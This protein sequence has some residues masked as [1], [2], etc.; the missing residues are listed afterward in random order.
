MDPGTLTELI[1]IHQRAVGQDGAGQPNAA[2]SK[3]ADEWASMRQL[4]GLE[5]IRAGAESA[6]ASASFRIRRRGTY[7]T[8]MRVVHAGV[9]YDIKAI[10]PDRIAREFE[11]LVCQALPG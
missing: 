4:N 3:L 2:W 6:L 1:E 8:A 5:T 10:S 9:T 7:T 11:D